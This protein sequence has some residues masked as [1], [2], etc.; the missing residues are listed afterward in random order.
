MPRK[1]IESPSPILAVLMDL[2]NSKIELDHRGRMQSV[3]AE[4]FSEQ[5]RK[6]VFLSLGKLSA[7]SARELA[8]TVDRLRA[9]F[10]MISDLAEA[11]EVV[12]DPQQQG[13]PEYYQASGLL[14]STRLEFPHVGG[15][16]QLIWNPGSTL[17]FEYEERD[18]WD[19]LI[20]ALMAVKSPTRIRACKICG[21]VY[22]ARRL[23]QKT[24]GP[25]HATAWRS[26]VYYNKHHRKEPTRKR[27]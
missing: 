16:R 20:E 24:C 27:E 25:A 23:G 22:W 6:G 3:I 11:D 21:D 2:A 5:A 14:K 26:R 9:T 7:L 4:L 8:A 15:R 1:Y 12:S 19:Y 10:K 13:S 17:A 18:L